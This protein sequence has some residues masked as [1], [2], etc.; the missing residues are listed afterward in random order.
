MTMTV[1]G[2]RPEVVRRRGA[3]RRGAPRYPEQLVSFAVQHAAS[4]QA[5][6]GRVS[7]AASEL[8]LSAMTLASWLSRSEV[9]V[10]GRLREVVVSEPPVRAGAPQLL[11][12][13][14]RSGHMVSGLDVAQ[15]VALLRALV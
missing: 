9:S 10:R 6:G 14:T 1:A 3:R 4:V 7:T 2:F 12:V 8:G 13:T 11:T 15:A 5:A